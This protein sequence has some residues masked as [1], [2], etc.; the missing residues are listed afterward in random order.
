MKTKSLE[1]PAGSELRSEWDWHRPFGREWDSQS[2]DSLK[3]ECC[4]RSCHQVM[5]AKSLSCNAGERPRPAG[6]HHDPFHNDWTSSWPL[7]L[8]EPT[9]TILRGVHDDTTMTTS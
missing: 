1:C 5:T 8:R 4:Q 9:F 7:H 6:D 3:R 2:E